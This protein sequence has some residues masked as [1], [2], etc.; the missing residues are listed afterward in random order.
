MHSFK[1]RNK[2]LKYL[3]KN[4]NID[5]KIN[6][7]G[8]KCDFILII[9]GLAYIY[10]EGRY[11]L[12]ENY[13]ILLEYVLEE[14]REKI[15]TVIIYHYDM[16]FKTNNI[17]NILINMKKTENELE[18]IFGVKIISEIKAKYLTIRETFELKKLSNY[19]ILDCAHIFNYGVK[20]ENVIVYQS[21]DDSTYNNSAIEIT[22]LKSIYVPIY[23]LNLI[24]IL[25]DFNLFMYIDNKIIT[26]IEK[27]NDRLKKV[28][29]EWNNPILPPEFYKNENNLSGELVNI[30]EDMN[31]KNFNLFVW[32]GIKSAKKPI[33][34]TWR[35]LW[36]NNNKQC[37]EC[38]EFSGSEQ[39]FGLCSV[40]KRAK[41]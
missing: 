23:N 11:Y 21:I 31:N 20:N 6:Q 27:M 22:E 13:K 10:E 29:S 3:N 28:S 39:N 35:E 2:Y 14:L 25:K 38:K 7:H 17:N 37:Y 4:K 30:F 16:K 32:L 24:Y 34:E 18:E 8:G 40:C 1:N 26:Y 12:H 41:Y 9:T 15:G 5:L 36:E 33:P 19:L